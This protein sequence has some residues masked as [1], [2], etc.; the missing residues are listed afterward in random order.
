MGWLCDRVVESGGFVVADFVCPTPETRAA[1]GKA[2]V[3]WVDRIKEGRFADTNR[4]FIAPDRY[5]IRVTDEGTARDWA[6][7]I[8]SV[9]RPQPIRAAPI[10]RESLRA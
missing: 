6:R 10:R 3:V 1:F 2:F 8:C 5:D 7:L 4:L 9:V